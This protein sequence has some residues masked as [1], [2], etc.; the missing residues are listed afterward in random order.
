MTRYRIWK[1]SKTLYGAMPWRIA[2]IPDHG[3][4]RVLHVRSHAHAI[5]VI[6][7]QRRFDDMLAK[8]QQAMRIAVCATKDDFT[9]AGP[10]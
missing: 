1:E 5:S 3:G 9:L 10:A 6:A 2:I 7:D 8:V 4:I